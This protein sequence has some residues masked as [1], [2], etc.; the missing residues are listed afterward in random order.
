M[1]SAQGRSLDEDMPL[2]VDALARRGIE[3]AAVDWDDAD[4]DWASV[5]LAV[6]RATWDYTDRAEEFGRWIDLVD[7]ATVL[8][9]PAAVLRWNVDKRYLADLAAAGAPV[10]PTT[11]VEPGDPVVLPDGEI[12]VKPAISAGSRDTDR[13]QPERHDDALAHARRLLEEGRVV[14]LQPYQHAVDDRGETALVYHLGRYSHGLRKGQI[15]GRG[16]GVVDDLYAEED[17]SVREP[18]ADEIAAATTI[19]DLLSDVGPGLSAHRLA[20]ARVDLVPGADGQPLLLELELVEPGLF[21]T[22]VPGSEDALA[23]AVVSL[24][25]EADDRGGAS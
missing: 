10:V 20:Y 1:T 4:F 15:L 11:F 2:A 18:T 19:L 3:V 8:A 6:V 9:N 24:L 21:N 5:D 13:Y 14:M 12:V 7:E 22:L 17:M 25:A 23:T 16:S